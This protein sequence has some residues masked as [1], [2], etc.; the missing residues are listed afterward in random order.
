MAQADMDAEK[1]AGAM[2]GAPEPRAANVAA[3][4]SVVMPAPV[5]GTVQEVFQ[6][7]T[8]NHYASLGPPAPMVFL[9]K[10]FWTR[11]VPAATLVQQLARGRE[12]EPIPRD[13]SAP[14]SPVEQPV[15]R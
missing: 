15:R 14:K 10:E 8:Q 2:A 5:A 11:E 3:G 4:L 12:A 13:K 6:D 1:I 9:G 7:Y